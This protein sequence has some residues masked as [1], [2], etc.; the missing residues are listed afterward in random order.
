MKSWTSAERHATRLTNFKLKLQQIDDIRLCGDNSVKILNNYVNYTVYGIHDD[1]VGL[2][3]NVRYFESMS[4]VQTTLESWREEDMHCYRVTI[5]D[6]Y[7]DAYV[8]EFRAEECF[9]FLNKQKVLSSMPGLKQELEKASNYKLVM[10]H[11]QISYTDCLGE[12]SSKYCISTDRL[13]SYTNFEEYWSKRRINCLAT[14][15]NYDERLKIY[16]REMTHFKLWINGLS[17]Q[18]NSV[19]TRLSFARDPGVQEISFKEIDLGYVQ[20]IAG[21]LVKIHDEK[22]IPLAKLRQA[23]LDK[24]RHLP[25]YTRRA[26]VYEAYVSYIEVARKLSMVK[27][28]HESPTSLIEYLPA[29]H[30]HDELHRTLE[31]VFQYVFWPD[32]SDF[33]LFEIDDKYIESMHMDIKAM[34]AD[35][36]RLA[37]LCLPWR[38]SNQMLTLVA[39]IGYRIL[40]EECTNMKTVQF[41]SINKKTVTRNDCVY[42]LKVR[43]S[44]IKMTDEKLICKLRNDLHTRE[45]VTL[46]KNMGCSNTSICRSHEG[47]YIIYNGQD[48]TVQPIQYKTL[49]SRIDLRQLRTRQ[50]VEIE[51]L[52]ELE[53]LNLSTDNFHTD[54]RLL[55]VISKGAI[56]NTQLVVYERTITSKVYRHLGSWSLDSLIT[57]V[58][59]SKAQV[60]G[61]LTQEEFTKNHSALFTSESCITLY[62]SGKHVIIS[63][64]RGNRYKPSR[65][66]HT[67]QIIALFKQVDASLV[68][69]D[70]MIQTIEC[71][72]Y[73][74]SLRSFNKT[75]G[76]DIGKHAAIINVINSG[77][78]QICACVKDRLEI[79]TDW[80]ACKAM[81]QIMPAEKELRYKTAC[82]VH[83]IS[84]SRRLCFVT[85]LK[86]DDRFCPMYTRSFMKIAILSIIEA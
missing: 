50:C 86:H 13:I 66:I 80:T 64:C 52:R 61:S 77:K 85:Y 55:A 18:L 54:G 65:A 68:H 79:V 83:W 69:C 21:L 26:E 48:T 81:L 75:A 16:R 20:H 17:S 8:K 82:F 25:A 6:K 34:K 44:M 9:G 71:D 15:E 36:D 56:G 31:L 35:N 76:I 59:L 73:F 60:P 63:I 38:H 58:L 62:C 41:A 32:D 22:V 39:D 19:Q 1:K 30:M 40:Y 23:T 10:K 67:T 84:F 46:N 47:M 53:E 28:N 33:W 74:S 29:S 78:Y 49:L 5:E 27:L 45:L 43:G 24:L 3:I 2:E 12:A 14:L 57:D 42:W 7:D 51:H 70:T 4:R 72:R 37:D 11:N